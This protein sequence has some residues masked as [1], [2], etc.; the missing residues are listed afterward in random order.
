M[1]AGR[2]ITAVLTVAVARTA[3]VGEMTLRFQVVAPGA[4]GASVSR[5][6]F[7]NVPAI[8]SIVQAPPRPVIVAGFAAVAAKPV[9]TRTRTT[10]AGLRC[11]S[12]VPA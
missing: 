12:A 3:L 10:V 5:A 1:L 7:G 2:A 8:P 11:P 6:S 4:V 9:I